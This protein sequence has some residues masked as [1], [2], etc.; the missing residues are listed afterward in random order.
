MDA[1]L[2][3]NAPPETEAPSEEEVQGERVTPSRRFEW[4]NVAI[5][6]ALV[7]LLIGAYFRFTGLNWDGN[8]HLHPDERFLT[9]VTTQL[10]PASSLTNYL[11][12]SESTLNPYNQ[13]QGFYVYGNFPMTVTRYAAELITRA[14]STLAENNPAEPPPCPY[15]YTAYDG[16]HLLGRFLSGLLDLFS[17]FFTFLIG[18]RLYGW[19][20]G[21]LASLLLA[22][23]VMPIQQSHFFTMD[24][25]A[26][27][28]TTITLYTAVRA[29]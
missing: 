11:R 17:V 10:Q 14:C 13:G 21:L 26:A 4:E 3:V 25:W 24:N 27:A 18:R 23:A 7:V 15:V 29:A 9:I 28:L 5:L 6:F 2:V 22:L 1:P 8:Y 19:K 20:A 12:T 16:V